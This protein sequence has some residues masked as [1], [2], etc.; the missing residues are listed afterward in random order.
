M[1]SLR[2]EVVTYIR[3]TYQSGEEYLWQRFPDYAVFRHKD[4]QKWFALIMDVA[5]GKLEM[6]QEEEVVDIINLKIPDAMLYDHLLSQKG[7]YPAYHMGR[8]RWLSLLL[9]GSVEL[10]EI[11]KWI[12]ESYGATASKAVKQAFRAPKEWIIPY[13]PKYYDI[14]KALGNSKEGLIDW[15]QGKGIRKGDTVFMYVAAP[16]SAVA[17]QFK[18][19]KTNIPCS[20]HDQG[21]HMRPLC[22]YVC[23]NAL[24]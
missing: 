21:I 13:N 12:A 9:D 22:P 7:F 10:S 17:Y 18:V 4:N 16:V 1:S 15:K 2:E 11:Q 5:R 8:G 24:M 6:S 20:F 14:Q 19:E 23:K 3:T